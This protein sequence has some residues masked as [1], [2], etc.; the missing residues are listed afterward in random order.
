MQKPH[1]RSRIPALKRLARRR[2]RRERRA[3]R[4]A[5]HLAAAAVLTCGAL[6]LAA[7]GERRP[8]PTVAATTGVLAD[9]A[10]EVA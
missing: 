1:S 10:R 9:V 5:R 2:L 4:L 7:C 6:G 3:G 8:E